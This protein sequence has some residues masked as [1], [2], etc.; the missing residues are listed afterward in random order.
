MSSDAPDL[1][2]IRMKRNAKLQQEQ[3]EKKLNQ[4]E[5]Q[6]QPTQASS[7]NAMQALPVM[8]PS[9]P[10]TQR[11]P[12]HPKPE[13]PMPT[14]VTTS[15][16]SSPS[17]TS[18]TP[19]TP[20]QPA[21]SMEDWTNEIY[22]RILQV[23]LDPG[24]VYKRGKCV[25]LH[26]LV[27][28]LEVES[29]PKP[30][31]L[32][33]QLLD[34]VILAR[35][36]IDP[37]V[38]HAELPDDIFATLQ[39]LHFD[40]LCH[41]WKQ[42]MDIR[43]NTVIR[44]K[45]VEK[46]VLDKRLAA[47]DHIRGLIVSYSGLV[48]Q[49]PDMFPQVESASPLGPLQLV[50]PLLAGPDSTEGMPVAYWSQLTQRF[51][52]DGLESIMGPAL[53]A[54]SKKVST[55]SVIGKFQDE[56]K[57]LSMLTD[58]KAF[59]GVLTSFP[60]F[61]PE[62]T[63]A[64][65]I[66][67]E[68]ILGGFFSLGTYPDR[69]SEPSVAD[70][71]FSGTED[72]NTNVRS[73]MNGLRGTVQGI[74]ATLFGITN[75]L[76]RANATARDGLLNYYT[77]VLLLNKNRRQMQAN[78]LLMSSESFMH[79]IATNLLRFC[80]P[81]LDVNHAKIDK[82]E[83]DY[84]RT[85]NRIDVKEETKIKADQQQSDAYY[86]D[87][88]VTDKHNFITEAFY[89]TLCFL[90]YGP[91]RAMSDFQ[92]CIKELQDSKK[93]LKHAEAALLAGNNSTP[94]PF[95]EYAITQLKNKLERLTKFKLVYE[96]MVLNP[97]LLDQMMNFYNLLM[98]WVLRLVDPTHKY[99]FEPMPLPLPEHVPDDF[100]ALPEF[101]I[102][103]ITEFFLFLGK[104]GYESRTISTHSQVDLVTFVITFLQNTS[105]IQNPHL[106][107]KLIEILFFFTYPVYQGQPGEL[108][109][110][111]NANPLALQH[112]IPALIAYYVEVELSGTDSMFY[113]KFNVR[114]H[115]SHVMKRIW[116]HPGHRERLREV[117]PDLFARFVNMLR[118]DMDY[119]VGDSIDNL[120]KIHGIQT[121]MENTQEWQAQ[122]QERIREQEQH[123]EQL[124]RQVQSTV[125][126]GNETVNMVRYMSAETVAP[127]MAE[128]VVDRLAA[129][130]DDTLLKLVG[131]KCTQLK[132]K[133]PKKY[134]F[135]PRA[136]LSKLI[137]IYL[138]LSCPTFV[139]AV[140]RDGRSYHKDHFARAANI[141]TKYNLKN[142]D[143]IQ[144]LQR[145][146]QLVEETLKQTTMEEEELANIP[147]EFEDPLMNILME[148]PVRLPSS[149][150]ILDRSTVQ[151]LWLG[152]AVDP[153]TREPFQ[154]EKVEPVPELKA[155]IA[156]W[157][158]ERAKKSAMDTQ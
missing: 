90:H 86:K 72:D 11:K 91:L 136:L 115:I 148:D 135:E 144:A 124:E 35:L 12:G 25:Y 33:D 151:S 8:K 93:Q 84:L 36:S 16:V 109:P 153:Y 78:M 76:V 130:L 141:L 119:L 98:A 2:Q 48:I 66:Q 69:L 27:E 105:Y 139:Q 61:N 14:P 9:Q 152:T 88:M 71:F 96:T 150:T 137:D 49:I 60:E 155:R 101:I 68:S 53:A 75:N 99:P 56:I 149:G 89:L 73:S 121:A 118:Q 81:F 46:S 142:E 87:A 116:N 67:S 79:S 147:D 64:I 103:D 113:E 50:N 3:E 58:D 77:H 156:A 131:E 80:E 157:K 31:R 7:S 38:P 102:S 132:V 112:L 23:T 140:A 13:S 59:A 4:A 92:N 74:E 47:L 97:L 41:S 106:K 134:Q 65:R 6:Q 24:A 51:K 120:I 34:R 37:N 5:K 85:S 133:N 110:I 117:G 52:D 45:N 128:G 42:V 32:N 28:E 107:P 43:H 15:A 62:T 20:Q 57:C 100:A 111:L 126:L 19:S 39:Q 158:A 125:A 21:K 122:T 114:Y 95:Q 127:F 22:A 40:Y 138:N 30:Y 70:A 18:P 145:F 44:S 17:T 82:I 123:L 108:E 83:T 63:D 54:I 1:E 55:S 94:A 143:Q 146:V 154:I 29:Y 10:V 129:M 26:D 104:Y